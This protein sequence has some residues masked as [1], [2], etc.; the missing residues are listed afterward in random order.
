[1]EK[2]PRVQL[3]IGFCLS[4][5]LHAQGLSSVTGTVTDPTGAIIPQAKISLVETGTGAQRSTVSDAQGRYS[6]LQM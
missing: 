2:N 6:F 5:G 3:L 4:V 1:M